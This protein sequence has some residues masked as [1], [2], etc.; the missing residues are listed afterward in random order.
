VEEIMQRRGEAGTIGSPRPLVAGQPVK[1]A[2]G[3]FDLE[4]L[5]EMKSGQ[6]RVVLLIKLLGRE[7]RASVPLSGLSA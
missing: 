2:M 5:F 7:V 3:R 4:G 1:V 6:D